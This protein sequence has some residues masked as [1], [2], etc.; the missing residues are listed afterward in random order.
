[1]ILKIFN[2]Q[3][4][5]TVFAKTKV[6]IAQQCISA[7]FMRQWGL[8]GVKIELRVGQNLWGYV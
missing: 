7:H 1:V 6:H 2:F 8:L 4:L 5:K 3:Y